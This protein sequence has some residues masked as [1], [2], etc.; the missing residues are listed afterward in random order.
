MP[1]TNNSMT[2]QMSVEKSDRPSETC[3]MHGCQWGACRMSSIKT[4]WL[5]C[6][7]PIRKHESNNSSQNNALLD[8]AIRCLLDLPTP[9]F[10]SF[11]SN[12]FL[13]VFS[14]DANRSVRFVYRL[15]INA[16]VFCVI[17]INLCIDYYTL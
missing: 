1:L 10:F 8:G 16:T 9:T 12:V 7:V 4:R 13:I 3:C 15:A 2:R 17:M 5:G 11:R 6:P 14:L